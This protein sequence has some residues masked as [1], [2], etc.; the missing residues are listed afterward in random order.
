ME[1]LPTFQLFNPP[2]LFTPFVLPAQVLQVQL[3]LRLRLSV[4]LVPPVLLRQL[5]LLYFPD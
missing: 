3:Q 2:Q 4:V 5:V 1:L